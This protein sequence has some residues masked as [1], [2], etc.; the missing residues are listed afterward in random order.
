MFLLPSP[1]AITPAGIKKSSANHPRRA[2]D[3]NLGRWD[4]SVRVR[5]P[6]PPRRAALRATLFRFGISRFLQTRRRVPKN[7]SRQHRPSHWYEIQQ[8]ARSWIARSPRSH[9]ASSP[10][11]WLS[12]HDRTARS[13]GAGESRASDVP[14]AFGFL[15]CQPRSLLAAWRQIRPASRR[16]RPVSSPSVF[17]TVCR[18]SRCAD[19]ESSRRNDY[20]SLSLVRRA[21]ARGRPAAGRR[22]RKTIPPLFVL[23]ARMGFS[24]AP[25]LHVR[26]RSRRQVARLRRRAIATHPRRSLRHLKVF[27][28]HNRP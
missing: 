28:H 12:F 6:N 24:P 26:R 5:R 16:L 10:L 18:V 27:S 4:E 7:P 9:R 21:P 14:P 3:D 19:P 1:S 17:A 25:V 2:N 20:K 8:H 23:L 11:P 22:R 15:D 13:G